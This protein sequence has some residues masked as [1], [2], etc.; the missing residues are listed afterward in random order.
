[1]VYI[2]NKSA[3]QGKKVIVFDLDGTIVR[4]DVN[5]QELKNILSN[6]YSKIF[7]E[8]CEFHSISECLSFVVAKDQKEELHNHF[9]IIREFEIKNIE[10]NIPIPQTIEL[11]KH[12]KKFGIPEDTK[13]AILSLN[14]RNT[15][16][17][18]LKQ[19]DILK[20]F[21][22]I[23]GRED[24]RRWKP[25]PE[26]LIIIKDHFNVETDEMLFIGDMKKD[27]LTGTNAGVK[28][29]LIDDLIQ[30]V[31]NQQKD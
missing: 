7:D 31:N 21:D 13:L 26:G 10:N 18:S 30:F 2:L 19:E 16:K 4:L 6:R 14:S 12:K 20:Y 29:Y 8:S 27:L 5:W 24:V 22:F 1:M 3:F 9:K 17:K 25:E 15:I 11:I 28:A 23:V